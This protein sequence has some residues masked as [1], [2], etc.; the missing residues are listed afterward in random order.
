MTLENAEELIRAKVACN[1]TG[2]YK[3]NGMRNT[4]FIGL[5]IDTFEVIV[6]PVVNFW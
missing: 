4:F 1:S 3:E 2:E 5:L 6:T